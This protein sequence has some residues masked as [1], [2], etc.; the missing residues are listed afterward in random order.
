MWVQIFRVCCADLDA[1]PAGCAATVMW[2]VTEF[3]Q[4][5]HER[6]GPWL[7][8]AGCLR[9]LCTLFVL[10]MPQVSH[11]AL[12]LGLTRLQNAVLEPQSTRGCWLW[13]ITLQPNKSCFAAAHG[14]IVEEEEEALP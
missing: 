10:C 9:I 3:I 4:L 1:L 12:E 6:E 13:S 7:K 2:E 14:K 5:T 11:E 8:P